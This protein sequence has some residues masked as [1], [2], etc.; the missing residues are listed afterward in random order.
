MAGAIRRG[1]LAAVTSLAVSPV[2]AASPGHQCLAALEG[3][4]SDARVSIETRCPALAEAARTEAPAPGWLLEPVSVAELRG[5]ARG[6][7][8]IEQGRITVEMDQVDQVV[9]ESHVPALPDWLRRLRE[10]LDSQAPEPA[11]EPNW[12]RAVADWLDANGHWLMPVLQGVLAV[13]ALGLIA[14]ILIGL[15]W[16]RMGRWRRTRYAAGEGRTGAAVAAPRRL[17]SVDELAPAE[18]VPAMLAWLVEEWE[19]NGRM[20]GARRMTNGL[21]RRRLDGAQA[22]SA[23][24]FRE[25]SLA[26]ESALFG[27]RVPDSERRRRCLQLAW[28]LARN[29]EGRR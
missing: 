6:F 18:Q 23:P 21:I 27:G 24:A 12:V 10:W 17:Q 26:A 22:D 19:R 8:P 1:L 5:L 20:P 13:V 15:R 7:T 14:W 9:A 16:P 11:E 4:P 2:L 29:Q 3:L 28:E 25:L